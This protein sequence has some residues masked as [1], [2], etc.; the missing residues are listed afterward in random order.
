M[1]LDENVEKVVVEVEE[2]PTGE[3]SEEAKEEGAE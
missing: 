1:S 3:S 2:T